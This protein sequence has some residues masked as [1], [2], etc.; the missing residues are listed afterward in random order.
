MPHASVKITPGVDQNETP[1]LNQTGLSYTNLVRFV[2]DRNGLGLVQKLGGWT[3]Y[4]SSSSAAQSSIVRSL[5]AWEDTNSN[6]WL[7][8][9]AETN[10]QTIN[11]TSM[12]NGV[13]YVIASVGT[14]NF[15][16]YGAPSNN[17][18]VAFIATGP[19]TGTGTVSTTNTKILSYINN[20]AQGFITP[21][22][23]TND[24]ILSAS[25]TLGSN[26]VT[27]ND[28]SSNI[29]SYDS[30][31]IVTPISVGGLILFGGYQCQ[32]IDANNFGIYATDTLG[33]PEYPTFATSSGIATTGASGS[34]GTATITYSGTYVFPVGTYVTV[35]GVTPTGYNG[36]YLVTASAAGTVS[37]AN[38]TTGSQTV[39]GT[40]K[41]NGFL[42]LF[43]TTTTSG[44]SSFITVTLPQHGYLVGED[45]AVLV[46]VTVG[47]ITIPVGNYLI[48]TV[49]SNGNSFTFTAPSTPS[50]A[51]SVYINSNLAE[52]RFYVG[53]GNSAPIP[54]YGESG[55][56]QGGYGTGTAITPQTGAPITA[57]DW[58]FDNF[59]QILIA[60]PAGGAIY[61]WDPTTSAP[62]ATFIPQGPNVNDGIF[63]AMPERQIVAWGSTFNGIQDPMLIRWCDAGNYTNWIAQSNNLA[64]SFRI[65]KGSKIVGC[66]QGPQQGLIWTDIALWSMQFIGYPDVYSFNELG[67]G[68]G[69][70]SRKAAASHNNVVYWM[71]QSQFY[72]LTGAGVQPLPC[73]IWDVVFQNLN[74]SY[75]SKIRIAVNSYFSEI[76]WFYPSL[77]STEN[78]SYVKYNSLLQQWDFGS[79]SRTAWINQ[80]VLGPP[81]GASSDQYIYQHETSND[82]NGAAMPSFFQTGYFAM[83]EGDLKVFIDQVWPDLKWGFY[84]GSTGGAG[85]P[86]G[87]A[88]QS[89]NAT[90]QLYFYV[91]DYPGQ[92]P[93]IYG[94]YSL[95]QA[96]QFITPR[97]R[98]RLVSIVVSNPSDSSGLGTFWRIGNMRYRFQPDGKY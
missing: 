89:P 52:Y 31:F 28:P 38:A 58:S 75:T 48:L 1:A 3:N 13:G 68:C 30:V 44:Q 50:S 25:T 60:C 57:S 53:I 88:Y 32:F 95:T 55:Y 71:G 39:A 82:A 97:F 77:N 83:Q 87:P 42:P 40:V 72:T 65:P 34:A 43:T 20:G 9:G 26:L 62:I 47:G 69:M 36:T 73:P 76:T 66:I 27:I 80:S 70:I 12:V 21:Q 81:I 64:G 23:F 33:N 14:T 37:Y 17:V 46:P 93:N 78:D 15:T 4:P 11:A 85:E 59:G 54:G 49:S 86:G 41:N 51:T 96:T 24:V 92:T 16:S 5:W 18:G 56:G 8:V 63:V 79:L 45:F 67:T 22:I 94:P 29:T 35:S 6:S 2:P 84:N 98:G 91:A 19:A 90:V 10:P 61:Q 74:R 7:A